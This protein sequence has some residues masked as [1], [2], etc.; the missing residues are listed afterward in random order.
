MLD[1]EL[2]RSVVAV[3]SVVVYLLE[4]LFHPELRLRLSICERRRC[5]LGERPA[6]N[7][8]TE[9]RFVGRSVRAVVEC[10]RTVVL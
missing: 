8:G 7:V 6:Y 2:Q 3:A 10:L 1:F 4:T 5:A 9:E